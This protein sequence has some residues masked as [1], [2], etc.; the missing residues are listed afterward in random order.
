M[1]TQVEI[2]NPWLTNCDAAAVTLEHGLP[3]GGWLALTLTRYG[4]FQAV[5]H[6]RDRRWVCVDD[7]T[8]LP[9]RGSWVCCTGLSFAE[10]HDHLK[11]LSTLAV[12]FFGWEAEEYGPR[13][14]HRL[15]LRAMA[16]HTPG[17]LRTTRH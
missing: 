5:V 1:S 10:A 2:A 12:R 14:R 9:D 16:R 4:E 6:S 11:A 3:D 15:I 8:G 7:L 17:Y 13:L